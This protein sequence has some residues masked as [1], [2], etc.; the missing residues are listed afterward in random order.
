MSRV[1]LISRKVESLSI[2]LVTRAS[3]KWVITVDESRLYHYDTEKS[4]KKK[5][6]GS[7][8]KRAHQVRLNLRVFFCTLLFLS[9]VM[10]TEAFPI[11]VVQ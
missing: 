4:V 6:W 10:T 7:Q 8:V 3:L 2:K 9:I 5:S 11:Q 1:A